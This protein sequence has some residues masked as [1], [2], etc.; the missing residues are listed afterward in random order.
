MKPKY[1]VEQIVEAIAASHLS[2]FAVDTEMGKVEVG[3]LLKRTTVLVT[4]DEDSLFIPYPPA[5][6]QTEWERVVL[7]SLRTALRIM[8]DNGE[9]GE[10]QVH[11]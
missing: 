10:T 3:S 8:F 7:S 11:N 1:S 5:L 9:K 6:E 2:L 4:S